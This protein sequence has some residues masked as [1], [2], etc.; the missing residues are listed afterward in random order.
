MIR[1]AIAAAAVL[2]VGGVGIW[3]YAQHWHPSEHSYPFQGIDVSR[4]QGTIDWQELPRQG[5]DFAYIKASEGGDFHDTQF[6]INWRAAGA[7]GIGR[8]AYHFFTL[9]RSGAE[10]A[11]NFLAAVPSDPGALPP[12]VDLEFGGNCSARPAR[13]TLLRELTTFLRLIEARSGKPALLYLTAEFD[14]AYQLSQAID[15]PLWLRRIYLEPDFAGRPWTL[16]QA[17]N[18][19][20]L[21]GIDGRVDWNAARLDLARIGPA[22]GA[23]GR[24]EKPR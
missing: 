24:A 9:C 23:Q 18:M 17:S 6:K 12:A 20:R 16:W 4:H 10:Q 19:R 2:L 15:R 22:F 3:L 1:S 5:V 13:E 11:A 21:S 7:A 8:G 14:D